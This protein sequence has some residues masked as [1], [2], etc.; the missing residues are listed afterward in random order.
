VAQSRDR[1]PHA[2]EL[3]ALSGISLPHTKER[4]LQ[5]AMAPGAVVS[6]VAGLEE[7]HLVVTGCRSLR[8]LGRSAKATARGW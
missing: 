3:P 5:E 8:L 7:K 2:V 1:C 6:D 4:I